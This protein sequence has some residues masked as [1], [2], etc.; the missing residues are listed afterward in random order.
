[1]QSP[2][3]AAAAHGYTSYVDPTLASIAIPVL[4]QDGKSDMAMIRELGRRC[5]AVATVKDGRRLILKPI[6]TATTSPGA[7]SPTATRSAGDRVPENQRARRLHQGRGAR[8]QRGS[9]RAQDGETKVRRL[10][11]TFHAKADA[12][13]SRAAAP[14]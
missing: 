13:A 5:H 10:K 11:K 9:G 2:Q 3:R 4:V 7:V 8:A 1:M 6:G 14:N 12:E